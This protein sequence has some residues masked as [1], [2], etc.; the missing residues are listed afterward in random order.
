MKNCVQGLFT[1]GQDQEEP[2]GDNSVDCARELLQ[3]LR[4]GSQEGAISEARVA[5]SGARAGQ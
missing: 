3:T 4:V 1:V 5:R 2:R